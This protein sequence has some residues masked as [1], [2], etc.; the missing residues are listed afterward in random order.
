MAY[1]ITIDAYSDDGVNRFV[2]TTPMIIDTINQRGHIMNSYVIGYSFGA[3]IEAIRES[4]SNHDHLFE[5]DVYYW[6]ETFN[7]EKDPILLDLT[8]DVTMLQSILSIS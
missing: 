6:P 4:I 5:A 7:V 8:D 2:V 1:S 3:A